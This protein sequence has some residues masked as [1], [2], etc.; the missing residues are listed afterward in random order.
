IDREQIR[1]IIQTTRGI[2]LVMTSASILLQPLFRRI[3]RRGVSPS[4]FP[5]PIDDTLTR[6]QML[7]R[8]V[9][10]EARQDSAALTVFVGARLGVLVTITSVGAGAMGVII[11][12]ALYPQVRSVRVVGTYIA[13]A[14]PLTLVAGLG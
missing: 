6:E 4:T 12:L 2:A 11:L 7:D 9:Q 14:V 5:A 1:G 13:H 8:E 10:C 3:F